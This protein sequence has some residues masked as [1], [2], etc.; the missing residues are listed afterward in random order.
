LLVIAHVFQLRA[1]AGR[2]HE[3]ALDYHVVKNEAPN[4]QVETG[5]GRPEAVVGIS[6]C[7][8]DCKSCRAKVDF[9]ERSQAPVRVSQLLGTKHQLFSTN[10]LIADS[11][12]WI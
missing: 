1:E 6:A 9:E 2:I 4:L 5:N 10:L 7:V 11:S 8:C 12:P 3:S